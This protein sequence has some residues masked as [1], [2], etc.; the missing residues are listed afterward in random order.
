MWLITGRS[1]ELPVF[2][3][4]VWATAG[5]SASGGQPDALLATDREDAFKFQ[6]HQRLPCV[7]GAVKNQIDF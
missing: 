5:I 2:G 7:K 4:W 6:P 1:F 3:L